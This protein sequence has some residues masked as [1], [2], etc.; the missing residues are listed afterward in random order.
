MASAALLADTSYIEARPG[1][2]I[3]ERYRPINAPRFV[4][5]KQEVKRVSTGLAPGLTLETTLPANPM[6][7]DALLRLHELKLLGADWDSYGSQAIIEDAFRPALEL[8]IEAVKRCKQ[9]T[10]VP[11]AN[12]GI[13]LRWVEHGKVLELDILPEGGVDAYFESQNGA[14]EPEGPVSADQ[15]THLLI[16][17]CQA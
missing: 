10:I 2:S 6:I 4:G 15:A 7:V 8:I 5:D 11:L 1:P 3:V 14:I 17:Y 12:G 13:G 9:P 16:Q